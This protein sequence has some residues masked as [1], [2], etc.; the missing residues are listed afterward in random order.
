MHELRREYHVAALTETSPVPL[1]PLA[2]LYVQEVPDLVAPEGPEGYDLLQVLWCPFSAHGRQATP[3]IQLRWRRAAD[4]APLADPPRPEVV[5]DADYVP[6]PCVLHPEQ[7]VEHEYIELL[8]EGLQERIEEWEEENEEEADGSDDSPT[9]EEDFSITPGWKVGGYAT[10]GVTG[11]YAISC[12]S[13]GQ[14]MELLLAINSLELGG[15]TGWIPLEDRALIGTPEVNTPTQVRVGRGGSL[16]V[17][18]CAA[19][20]RHDYTV[21]LQ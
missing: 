1:V 2:Q 14:S 4:C 16:N 11:P 13:C 3:D 21:V 12:P 8:S 10:W 9:Y 18:R 15:N 7:V 20:L 5:G 17:F 19:D 6:E